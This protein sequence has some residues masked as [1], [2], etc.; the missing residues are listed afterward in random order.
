MYQSGYK[1]FYDERR[2]ETYAQ[3]YSRIRP[4]EH[5]HYSELKVFIEKYSLR[6]KACLE[7]GS[8]GGFFQD[9]VDDY[10]G[11]D[12]ADSLARHYHKPYRV[13]K[14]NRYP[15]DDEMFDAIWTITVFE[16]IPHLQQALLE[17]K[18]L[19]KPGG[20]LL[21]APAW[22]CRPWAADGFA[23]RPYSDFGLKGKL[24]K[25]L[26]PIRNSVMWRGLS[27]FPLRLYHHLRFW[28]GHRYSEIC[29]KKLSPNYE[30][31]WT[32]DSDACNH[33]DP[34]DAI[35]WFESNG[36]D[37]LSHPLHVRSFCVRTGPLVFRKRK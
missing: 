26:I 9:M 4:E 31:F 2:H 1:S 16:H 34:H 19:L 8:S 6:D 21:F 30:V 18:R 20:V 15:Y 5:G 13:A 11:T 17:I 14:G 33:I 23:V 25:A 35:M 32:S 7:I 29:Y 37:C 10:Y 22:Q 27:V 28:L 3:D 36:F 12:I 24:I